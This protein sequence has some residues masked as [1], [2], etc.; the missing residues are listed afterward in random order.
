MQFSE[1]LLYHIWDA[2]HLQKNLKTISSRSIKVLFPGRWNTGSGPDF[3]DA[4]I[5]IDGI[6]KRGDVELEIDS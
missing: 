4:I 5:E 1:K 6:V 3:K 2:Q